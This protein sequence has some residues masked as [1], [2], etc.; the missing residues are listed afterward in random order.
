MLY[1]HSLKNNFHTGDL[2]KQ[3]CSELNRKFLLSHGFSTWWIIPRNAE[4]LFSSLWSRISRQSVQNIVNKFRQH[5]TLLNQWKGNSGCQRTVW[6]E[7][8]IAQIEEALIGGPMSF[9]RIASNIEDNSYSS[10][11]NFLRNQV[12]GTSRLASQKSRPHHMW[13]FFSRDT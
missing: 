6:N 8:N 11:R 3:W 12:W 13:F 4:R 7:E 2:S 5:G 9:R 1:S 10:V